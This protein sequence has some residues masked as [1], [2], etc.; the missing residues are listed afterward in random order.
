MK[1]YRIQTT[2]MVEIERVFWVKASSKGEASHILE[3]A[4]RE[5]DALDLFCHK[6]ETYTEYDTSVDSAR[7]V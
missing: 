7:E 1:E 3:N 6:D 5:G 2:V 4:L